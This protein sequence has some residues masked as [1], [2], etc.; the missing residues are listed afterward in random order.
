[1]SN[2]HS[3][4]KDVK[5][6]ILLRIKNDGLS[7]SQAAQEHGVCNRTIYGWLKKEAVTSI[8]FLEYSKLKR[9]NRLLLEL[10]GKLSLEK[11]Q[12]NHLKKN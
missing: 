2:F 1:M 7:V 8:S 3:I 9:E 10:V 5:S 11:S 4:P 6:Q 12:Q